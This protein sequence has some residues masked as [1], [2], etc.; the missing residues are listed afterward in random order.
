MGDDSDLERSEEPTARRLEQARSEGQIARSQELP[1]AAVL[2]SAMALFLF[3]GP[4]FFTETAK[5]FAQG[6]RIDYRALEAPRLMLKIFADFA[7]E[8]LILVIP[9]FIVCAVVGF[10][11]NIVTGGFNFAPKAMTPKFS[12][13]NPLTGLQRIFGI[14]S[15]VELFKAVLKFSVVTTALYLVI[16]L[17]LDEF[18]MLSLM[19]LEPA[20]A[21]SAELIGFC[22]I[23]VAASLIIIALVDV[24]WQKHSF[25]E[26]MKMTK[27]QVKDEMKDAEGRPEVKSQIRK[28]QREMAANRMMQ[29]VKDADVVVTNPEHFSVA[30]AYDPASDGAPVVL[31]MGVDELAFRIREEAK[32]HGVTIFPAPPLARALYYTSEVDQPIHHDLYIAVAQVI[33]YVFNLNST[34]PD[35]SLPAKPD[36]SVPESMKFD[37]LGRKAATQ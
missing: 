11:A 23:V 3:F 29:K 30:L 25:H 2:V 17:K 31:A 36:P 4:W 10:S 37:A 19:P 1:T 35:G 8:S 33:A 26:R 22:A 15:L 32:N 5:L 18:L 12:K 7:I 28:R 9:V 20:M 13:M 21:K 16:S 34:N 6:F 27:Q 24:P 14:N